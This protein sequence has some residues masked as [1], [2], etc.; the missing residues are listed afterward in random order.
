M[1]GNDTGFGWFYQTDAAGEIISY[2]FNVSRSLINI[3]VKKSFRGREISLRKKE[4]EI[5]EFL[6]MNK[7]RAVSKEMLLEHVWDGGLYIFSNIVEVYIRNIRLALQKSG[8]KKVI[9]TIRGFG[10]IIEG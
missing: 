3:R 6:I 10:Y 1:L 5:L 8:A 2:S 7:S 4:Y 9:K